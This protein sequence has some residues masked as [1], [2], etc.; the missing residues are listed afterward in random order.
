MGSRFNPVQRPCDFSDD[1]E[2]GSF[3][4]EMVATLE[5]CA[6][7]I[8]ASE[9]ATEAYIAANAG[10]ASENAEAGLSPGRIKTR[11]H[12]DD[13]SRYARG[14]REGYAFDRRVVVRLE[15]DVR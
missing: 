3:S 9:Q 8:D 11:A 15:I 12:G 5:E 10:R 1:L 7:I 6:A 2:I 14:D 13:S 4:P